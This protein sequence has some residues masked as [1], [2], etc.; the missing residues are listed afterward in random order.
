MMSDTLR[1]K[2]DARGRFQLAQGVITG[3]VEALIRTEAPV[4]AAQQSELRAA[5]LDQYS[6]FGN[7]LSGA[8]ADPS[9]L[10]AVARLPFVQKIELSRPLFEEGSA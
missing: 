8:I 4:T 1:R 2:V 9:R 10:E 7:V 5:G 3:A 6:A